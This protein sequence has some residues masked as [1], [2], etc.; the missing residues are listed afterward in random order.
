MID[1]AELYARATADAAEQIKQLRADNAKLS[2]AVASFHS[3][4]RE[5]LLL[6]TETK[7]LLKLYDEQKKLLKITLGKQ[8]T[9]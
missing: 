7:V 9:D 2:D 1:Y 5:L 8:G 6:S 3:V 4:I